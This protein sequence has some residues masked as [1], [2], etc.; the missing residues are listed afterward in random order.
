MSLFVPQ[1][2]KV[3][4]EPEMLRL[5]PGVLPL[6]YAHLLDYTP[7]NEPAREPKLLPGLYTA[8]SLPRLLLVRGL[9]TCTHILLSS[10]KLEFSH[11]TR[12]W[13]AFLNLSPVSSLLK[14]GSNLSGTVLPAS[15]FRFFFIDTYVS[16]GRGIGGRIHAVRGEKKR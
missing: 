2:K 14:A 8:N 5:Q 1:I 13:T 4:L 6:S 3:P 12:T 15:L 9:H 11:Y 7:T 16:N 10:S